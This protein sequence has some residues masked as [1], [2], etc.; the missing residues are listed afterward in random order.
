M[1]RIHVHLHLEA[2]KPRIGG[3]GAF[4]LTPNGVLW[5]ATGQK[6]FPE[7]AEGQVALGVDVEATFWPWSAV[8]HISMEKGAA[9]ELGFSKPKGLA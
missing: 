6:D 1:A 4:Q 7:G 2:G 9:E 8:S 5:W 3:A